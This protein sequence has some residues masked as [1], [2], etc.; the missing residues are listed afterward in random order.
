MGTITL[1]SDPLAKEGAT[2][3]YVGPADECD[4]CGLK[5]ICH[6]LDP[7]RYYKVTKLRKVEHPCAVHLNDRVHVVEVEELPM[8]TSIPQRKA[9]EAALIILDE[10]ECPK[11]WCPNYLLCT[12]PEGI[13]GKKILILEIKEL[14]ECPRGLKLKRAMIESK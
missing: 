13:R 10:P 12:L 9:M 14:L 7:G 8:E 3:R 5:E 11:K 6:K 2:F 1:I 4:G